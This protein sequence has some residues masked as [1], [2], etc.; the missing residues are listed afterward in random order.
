MLPGPEWRVRTV[1]SMVRTIR[2]AAL[3]I[4]KAMNEITLD[5]HTNPMRIQKKTPIRYKLNQAW[6]FSGHFVWNI[7]IWRLQKCPKKCPTYRIAKNSDTRLGIDFIAWYRIEEL[8]KTCS[9]VSNVASWN[10]KIVDQPSEPSVV[11]YEMVTDL[12]EW[13]DHFVVQNPQNQ[14]WIEK[15][16][17]N[18]LHHKIPNLKYSYVT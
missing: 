18:R 12:N 6:M 5:N 8:F 7:S 15:W 13:G 9:I 1:W 10:R 17:N 3:I 11:S 2:S 14:L 16:A 4:Q